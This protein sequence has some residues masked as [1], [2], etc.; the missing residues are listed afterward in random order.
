MGLFDADLV[1][2]LEVL[3]FRKSMRVT[4]NNNTNLWIKVLAP[5][6]QEPAHFY[7]HGTD[8]SGN[9]FCI[10]SI[11][12][13][14][15]RVEVRKPQDPIALDMININTPNDQRENHLLTLYRSIDPTDSKRYSG[16]PPKQLL[17]VANER[18]TSADGIQALGAFL[19]RV[20]NIIEDRGPSNFKLAF[21]DTRGKRIY[22]TILSGANN[23]HECL[24]NRQVVLK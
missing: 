2:Y 1:R 11:D 9:R 24:H 8:K 10:I 17:K 20:I 19:K 5:G 7:T 16:K 12:E 3:I 13:T 23:I 18:L 21:G 14:M 22:N 15:D 6:E 4:D